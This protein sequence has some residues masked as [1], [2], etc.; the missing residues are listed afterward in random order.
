[1]KSLKLN[2]IL[3]GVDGGWDVLLLSVDRYAEEVGGIAGSRGACWREERKSPPWCEF[4]EGGA[5]SNCA[6]ARS[7]GVGGVIVGSI[8]TWRW[9]PS[10]P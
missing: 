5:G 8:G 7:V 10:I 3:P 2:G 1:M 6:G 4:G 9:P